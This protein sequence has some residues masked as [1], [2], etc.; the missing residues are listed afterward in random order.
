MQRW[1]TVV[2]IQKSNIHSG[3]IGCICVVWGV[4]RGRKEG[5]R[6]K[7]KRYRQRGRQRSDLNSLV[8]LIKIFLLRKRSV[9]EGCMPERYIIRFAVLIVKQH[10]L[11]YLKM[12]QCYYSYSVRNELK[13]SKTRGKGVS[14]SILQPMRLELSRVRVAKMERCGS[15]RSS[16]G[17][18]VMAWRWKEDNK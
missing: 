13:E 18:R 6:Q 5:C 2:G 10:D 12:L 4:S 16:A 11:G 15:T 7:D 3:Q 17:N 1:G 14:Y 8:G 9:F